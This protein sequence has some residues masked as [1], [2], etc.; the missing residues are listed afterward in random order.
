LQY[1]VFRVA[2]SDQRRF[3]KVLVGTAEED[4]VLVPE[5]TT[6]SETETHFWGWGD[7]KFFSQQDTSYLLRCLKALHAVL[8]SICC[9]LGVTQ[10]R[11]APNF[12]YAKASNNNATW[13]TSYFTFKDSDLDVEDPLLFLVR[14]LLQPLVL[15]WGVFV[16]GNE[17]TKYDF[18]I[19]K[20]VE[21]N[22]D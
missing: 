4:D 22:G 7:S 15:F 16:G 1:S 18:S 8:N 12:R 6:D 14:N 3:G 17:W 20:V 13:Y 5:M 21:K 11:G 19:G 9:L 10:E 2:N